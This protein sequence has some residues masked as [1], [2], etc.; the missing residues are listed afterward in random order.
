MMIRPQEARIRHWENC[1][2]GSGTLRCLEMLA[3]Y[4]RPRPGIKFYHDN[5]LPPGAGIGEHR[6]TKDEE[7]YIFLEGRGTMTVDGQDE[8]VGPGDVCLTRQGHSHA[9]RNDGPEPLHFLVLGVVLPPA[10]P[11]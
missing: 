3:D 6:H 7:I 10:E 4:Q 11:A 9:L 5:V 1:H 8:P 2:G